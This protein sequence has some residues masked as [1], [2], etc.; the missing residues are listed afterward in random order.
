MRTLRSGDR[1]EGDSQGVEGL[2]AQESQEEAAT[3]MGEG[4]EEEEEQLPSLE[5]AVEEC[6]T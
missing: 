5:E 3:M 2:A 4:E 1:T 6:P